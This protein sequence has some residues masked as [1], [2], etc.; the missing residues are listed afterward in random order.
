MSQKT[1]EQKKARK[2]ELLAQQRDYGRMAF[3]GVP[4][5]KN[6]LKAIDAELADLD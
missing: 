6:R 3:N 2:A 1:D 5:A 4:G